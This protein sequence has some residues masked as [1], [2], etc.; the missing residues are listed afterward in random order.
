MLSSTIQR[1]P[2]LRTAYRFD[3]V[4]T[5]N[6][7]HEVWYQQ[8]RLQQQCSILN[9]FHGRLHFNTNIPSSI[10][11]SST[12]GAPAPGMYTATPVAERPLPSSARLRCK[13]APSSHGCTLVDF[14]AEVRSNDCGTPVDF[15]GYCHGLP[16]ESAGFHGKR[17]GS[18]HFHGQCQGSLHI[19]GKCH[20]CGHGTY[21]GSVRGKLRRTNHSN[22]QKSTS[23]ATVFSAELP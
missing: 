3:F 20:G 17:H 15:H 1:R 16:G 9:Q 2:S 10:V 19:H 21:H 12:G 14:L 11:L 6:L 13:L 23:I 18:C 5:V 4:P 8:T 22:P 7:S